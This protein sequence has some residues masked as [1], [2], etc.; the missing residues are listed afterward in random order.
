MILQKDISNS[1]LARW[2]HQQICTSWLAHSHDQRGTGT[3]QVAHL[4]VQWGYPSKL[5][6]LRDQQE[7]TLSVWCICVPS[8]EHNEVLLMKGCWSSHAVKACYSIQSFQVK[9]DP[10]ELLLR[11]Y[12]WILPP[13]CCPVS[14]DK[15]WLNHT[16]K[17]YMCC[18]KQLER[19]ATRSEV[20]LFIEFFWLSSV[21]EQEM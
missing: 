16:F 9:D 11:C 18:C 13:R 2:C 20:V 12:H 15:P 5:T 6:H 21:V 8:T 14:F 3:S 4:L 1:L 19:A 10:K 17:H 7:F